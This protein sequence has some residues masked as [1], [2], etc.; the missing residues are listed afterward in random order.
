MTGQAPVLIE[1][2]GYGWGTAPIAHLIVDVRD[3]FRDPHVSPE[4]RQL[5]ATDERVVRAVLGTP[6]V[7]AL[8]RS[9]VLAARA[10]LDGPSPGPVM[11]AVGCVGGRH[12][13]A[14]IASEVARLLEYV[15]GGTRAAVSHRDMGRP[16]IER[17]SGGAS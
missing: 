3:H 9:I 15:Y 1:S 17:P 4:L 7:P 6:G 8:V 5:T 12:R 10:F 14:V 13:S 11:V 16:V 2:F